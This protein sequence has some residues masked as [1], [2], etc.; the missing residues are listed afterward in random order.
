[1][2]VLW[3]WS[4]PYDSDT[5]RN[6][7]DID[8]R[9]ARMRL[10]KKTVFHYSRHFLF[11]QC[12]WM[13]F[14]YAAVAPAVSQSNALINNESTVE[15]TPALIV[16]KQVQEV[17]LVITV[18]DHR[19]RLVRDLNSSDFNIQDNG[20]LPKRITYFE[21]Q[22]NLPLRI[23]VV[24]DTSSSIAENFVVEEKTAGLFLTRSMRPA[25]DLGLVI[26]FAHKPRVA[27]PATNDTKL[28][29]RTIH[30][31][32]IGGETAI[33]DAVSMAAS[34][35]GKIKDVQPTRRVIILITDGED[36][37]S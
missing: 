3:G 21:R 36:N 11:G 18:T 24:V 4:T 32:K 29:S 23:A 30:S 17:N 2:T 10:T 8:R 5:E 25:S 37:V 12:V 14:F 9:V 26:G 27:Q 1:M 13:I 6:N 16:H 28:L 19:G 35:L 34:E 31:L 7:F 20:E 33:Y 22:A 15:R